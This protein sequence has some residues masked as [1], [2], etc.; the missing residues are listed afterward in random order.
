MKKQ[1]NISKKTPLQ[2][3]KSLEL[4]EMHTLLKKVKVHGL[5][6]IYDLERLIK[7]FPFKHKFI[8]HKIK[9]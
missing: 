3:L 9:F 6:N 8:K 5:I 7:K 2:K 4:R 1:R